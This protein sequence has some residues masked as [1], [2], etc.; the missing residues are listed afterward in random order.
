MRGEHRRNRST[1]EMSKG[2]SPHARGAQ[3]IREE[4]TAKAGIIPACAGSTV[5]ATIGTELVPGSSP[6]ARGARRVRPHRRAGRGIIPACAGSTRG[7]SCTWPIGG[8]HPRMRGEHSLYLVEE[9]RMKGS[10][11]HARGARIHVKR[12]GGWIGIIPACAGST[13]FACCLY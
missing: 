13:L 11:P 5:S 6:H 1:A 2:S 3:A 10:S 7:P 9:A 4:K 12:T 8:D